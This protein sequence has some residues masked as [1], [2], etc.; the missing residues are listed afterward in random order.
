MKSSTVERLAPGDL[1]AMAQCMAIDAGAFPYASAQFGARA[2]TAR[3]FVAREDGRV[4]GF[5]AARLRRR[6]MHVEGLA[7]EP[8]GRRAGIGRAL[9]RAAIEHGHATRLEGVSLHVSVTNR[10]AIRLYE[11]E[12]FSV[13]R[14]LRGFYP[15]RFFGAGGDALEMVLRLGRLGD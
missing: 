5:L 4:V 10:A 14:P 2:A 12:G 13:V 11:S 7:V 1:V 8:E 9:V 3:V 6:T 15:L